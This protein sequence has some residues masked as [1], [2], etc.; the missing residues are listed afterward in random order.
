LIILE[1]NPHRSIT[2]G[3][4]GDTVFHQMRYSSVGRVHIWVGI[5]GHR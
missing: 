4:A 1:V 3:L 2:F 5:C